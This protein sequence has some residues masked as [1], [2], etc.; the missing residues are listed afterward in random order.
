[1]NDMTTKTR[2]RNDFTHARYLMR[3]ADQMM[4]GQKN[5]SIE[6]MEIIANEL[7]A[8]AATFAQYVEEQKEVEA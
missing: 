5:P 2:V 6:D 4:T 1:M 3:V 8:C 7:I